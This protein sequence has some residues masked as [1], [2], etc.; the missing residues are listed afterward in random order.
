MGNTDRESIV[1]GIARTLFVCAYADGIEAG[2]L[3][4]PR[5]GPGEDWNNV[6]PRLGE[7]DSPEY[8]K[9]REIADLFDHAARTNLRRYLVTGVPAGITPLELAAMVYAE[10]TGTDRFA[11][12]LAMKALGTGVGLEDDLPPG[13]RLPDWIGASVPSVA[14]TFY[15]L[16]PERFPFRADYAPD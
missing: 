1:W 11:H 4:G 5:A 9:A 14:F 2:A 10:R 15:D 12:C 7:V 13:V 6:A 8:L 3:D 16:D